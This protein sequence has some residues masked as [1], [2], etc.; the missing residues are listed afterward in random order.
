MSFQIGPARIGILFCL[1]LC[2]ILLGCASGTQKR[3]SASPQ[4]ERAIEHP[5]EECLPIFFELGSS[6][7]ENP[8]GYLKYLPPQNL[9]EWIDWLNS[10]PTTRV[11][12]QGHCDERE[13]KSLG[14]LRADSIREYLIMKGIPPSRLIA[15]N[16]GN[17]CP[18][19]IGSNEMAWAQNRRVELVLYGN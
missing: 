3:P 18:M 15:V 10:H 12:V 13:D 1:N 7:F 8:Q 2:A 19:S 6:N 4:G 9:D 14:Q 16:C 11:R 5:V 17:S